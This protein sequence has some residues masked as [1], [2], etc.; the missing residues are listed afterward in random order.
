MRTDTK[1]LVDAQ[2]QLQQAEIMGHVSCDATDQLWAKSNILK[3]TGCKNVSKQG[4]IG[5]R[6]GN[7][8]QCHS[9]GHDVG[10]NSRK[11]AEEEECGCFTE[12]LLGRVSTL[13][14]GEE[15][16]N[17]G[18][19]CD[20]HHKPVHTCTCLIKALFQVWN[21]T[22]CTFRNKSI[23]SS[24]VWYLPT[25]TII[26]KSYVSQERFSN[27]HGRI[28]H[29]SNIISFKRMKGFLLL[30]SLPT[31]LLNCLLVT[32]ET[33]TVHCQCFLKCFFNPF[34]SWPLEHTDAYTAMHSHSATHRKLGNKHTSSCLGVECTPCTFALRWISHSTIL[35]TEYSLL[36]HRVPSQSSL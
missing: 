32:S 2:S 34:R 10:I 27:L 17:N 9:R 5:V 8:C 28:A 14:D 36:R 1:I 30:G 11:D 26:V 22:V 24:L 29:T 13:Y 23:W 31:V 21:E 16:V 4:Q 3:V 35:A 6:E 25:I 7:N 18:S 12:R 15:A 20:V 19:F 33:G